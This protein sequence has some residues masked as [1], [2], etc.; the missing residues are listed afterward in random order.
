MPQLMPIPCKEGLLYIGH[1]IHDEFHQAAVEDVAA[2]ENAVGRKEFPDLAL[3]VGARGADVFFVLGTDDIPENVQN[4]A[5]FGA[6]GDIM[7]PVGEVQV[8]HDGKTASPT[9]AI[10]FH[11]MGGHLPKV[12][13]DR[14][15]DLALWLDD[16]HQ[17]DHVAGV[18]QGDVQVGVTRGI[19]FQAAASYYLVEQRQ[20]AFAGDVQVTCQN[21]IGDD[22]QG[23]V[24]VTA[25]AEGASN[26]PVEDFGILT[27]HVSTVD[28]K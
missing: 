8:G 14:P 22:G 16:P 9:A 7:P 28:K 2:L 21:P 20:R 12:G 11:T 13:A 23:L 1:R 27:K 10:V 18:V 5:E 19:Q 3:A 15:N 26:L 6:P 4:L 25:L 24:G 17:A